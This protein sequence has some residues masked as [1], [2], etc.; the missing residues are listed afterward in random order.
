MEELSTFAVIPARRTNWSRNAC[1]RHSFNFGWYAADECMATGGFFKI[2]NPACR[3]CS[4]SRSAV[5]CAMY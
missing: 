3:S 4:T 5:I 1:R 2:T